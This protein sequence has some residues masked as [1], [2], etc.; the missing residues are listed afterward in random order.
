[1]DD[2]LELGVANGLEG[3]VELAGS[4]GGS[5]GENREELHDGIERCCGVM[6]F[7]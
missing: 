3:D 7:I 6:V 1:M 5:A 4:N 2:S